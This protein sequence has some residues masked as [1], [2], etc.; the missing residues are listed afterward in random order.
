M[1]VSTSKY[2]LSCFSS[3][4]L[5]GIF[6]PAVVDFNKREHIRRQKERFIEKGKRGSKQTFLIII[7]IIIIIIIRMTR[8][9]NKDMLTLVEEEQN[10]ETTQ[11][12][13]LLRSARNTQKSPIDLIVFV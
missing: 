8:T 3:H 5:L 9:K 1:F 4:F 10:L 13:A 11:T 2:L 6:L 12:T 7:I